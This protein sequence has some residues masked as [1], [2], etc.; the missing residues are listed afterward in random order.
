M[1]PLK[2]ILPATLL[3]LSLSL[4]TF[5]GDMSTPGLVLPP[6]PP[7]QASSIQSGG[8]S[9]APN[10]INLTGLALDIWLSLRSII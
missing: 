2:L 4:S 6:P 10:N 1:K 3:S 5:A 8:D 9:P 7:E